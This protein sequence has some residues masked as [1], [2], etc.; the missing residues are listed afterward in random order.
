MGRET[1]L[2][3]LLAASANML[4]G[5]WLT[6]PRNKGS[7]TPLTYLLAVGAGFLLAAV[8]LGVVPASLGLE[9]WRDR[10]EIP[11]LLVLGGYLLIQFFEHTVAPHFHFGEETHRDA[12]L[13]A[14]AMAAAVGGLALHTFFD[15]VAIASSATVSSRL[16]LI[17]FIAILLHKVPEGFTVASIVLASGR[18]PR[19]ARGATAIVALATLAGVAAV[20]AG[21]D[22]VVYA[23]PL[24]AGVTLYVA[25]SDL[26]PEINKSERG[27]TSLIV[28]GGVA[29]YYVTE[30]I[31]ETVG[32]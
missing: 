13:H 3:G 14:P 5:F 16:G 24:S 18:S 2:Y 32:L 29:L 27:I 25:T 7:R 12:V 15:G 8:F 6:V 4:G 1:L 23:L 17:V 28:F 22:S 11:L 26:I 31:L 19:A 9:H 20:A 30:K 21:K 10:M